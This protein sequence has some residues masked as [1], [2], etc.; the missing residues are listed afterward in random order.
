MQKTYSLIQIRLHWVIAALVVLQFLVQQGMVDAMQALREE[1]PPLAME[2][3]LSNIHLLGGI[4]IFILMSWRLVLRVTL[5]TPGQP[6]GTS[7]P[8]YRVAQLLH[9]LF[10]LVLIVMPVSGMLSYYQLAGW[11]R[12]VHAGCK[13]LLLALIVLHVLAALAHRFLLRDAVFQRMV[14]SLKPRRLK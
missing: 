6:A 12:A 1:R 2:F 11:A 7:R 14:S 3:V 10:Y 13:P 9:W 8:I 5:G 4:T